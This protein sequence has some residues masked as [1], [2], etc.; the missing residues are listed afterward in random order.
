MGQ[1]RRVVVTGAAGRIARAVRKPL[2]ARWDLYETDVVAGDRIGALDVTDPQACLSAFAGADA[3]IH[4]AAVPA[5]DATWE[6]LLPANVIGAH[7]VATA[8]A[9]CGVRRLVLASSLQA[10]SAAPGHRQLRSEDQGRP[11]NLYGATKVWAEALGSWVAAT[12]QTSVV[13]L[14]IGYFSAERPDP[15]AVTPRERAAWL[16]ARDAAELLRAAVEADV[17]FAV[18]NGTSANRYPLADLHDTQVELGYRPVDDAWA[19]PGDPAR[20][21]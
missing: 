7:A 14:R 4:L 10:V 12:S 16:S 9:A 15:A 1:R 13:A 11:A 5:P 19:D 20:P 21:S 18:A 3:V 6:E 17:R 8:A 2:A